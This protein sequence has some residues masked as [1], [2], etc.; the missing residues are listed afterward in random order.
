[1]VDVFDIKGKEVQLATAEDDDAWRFFVL[2]FGEDDMA[3]SIAEL[4]IDLNVMYQIRSG[5]FIAVIG[6]EPGTGD[7]VISMADFSDP[8]KPR[9]RATYRLSEDIQHIYSGAYRGYWSFYDY[10]W[11][12]NAGQPLESQL[13]PATTRIVRADA[14]GR[15][16][17]QNQLRL[18]DLRNPD[19]PTLAAGSLD[20]PDYPFVNK[21]GH[22]KMLYSTHTE[23]ALDANGNPK[24]Y[25]E[26]WFLD[27]VDASDPAKLTARAKV[28]IPGRLVDVDSTGTLLYTVDYQWDEHGQRRNSFNVLKLENDVATL[29]TVLPV[30]DEIDRARYL[31][32]E[33]WLSTHSYP[34][35]GRAD[36]SPDSR[37]PYT[38]LTRLRLDGQGNVASNDSHD[39]SG[40]H[41]DLLDIDGTKVYLASSYPTGLLILDTADFANPRIVGASRTVGYVS[42][43]VRSGDFLYLPMGSYGVRRVQGN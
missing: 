16:F 20:M 3:K 25:H 42:K 31:D 11:N 7:Q 17:Y 21:V 30:G 13:L 41:F 29:V 28:N 43:L 22:G 26:R 12:P 14:N 18:I 9:W 23:P 35:Y 39:V 10:Y 8:T 40:Y 37:Q 2:P 34:W 38:R 24:Q 15:R 32:R 1:V 4:P 5:D 27:R 6:T 33:I 36:D 19:M